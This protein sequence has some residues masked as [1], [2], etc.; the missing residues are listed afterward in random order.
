[1]ILL[2]C[3]SDCVISLLKTLLQLPVSLGGRASQHPEVPTGLGPPFA[4]KLIS[5]RCPPWLVPATP[6]P[7][8]QSLNMP[9]TRLP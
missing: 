4:S 6:P 1:M 5:Y 3:K 2:K 7:Q 8:T 9:D